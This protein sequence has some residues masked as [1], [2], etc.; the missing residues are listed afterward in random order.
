MLGAF[1]V[2]ILYALLG[3]GEVLLWEERKLRNVVTYGVLMGVVCIL[4]ALLA[5]GIEPPKG[6][7]RSLVLGVIQRLGIGG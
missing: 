1:A 5:L 4:T 6:I 3:V 7:L 2:V